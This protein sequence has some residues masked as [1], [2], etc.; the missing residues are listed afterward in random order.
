MELDRV[1]IERDS[2][3][4]ERDNIQQLFD[5]VQLEAEVSPC[6]LDP[7]K[8]KHLSLSDDAGPNQIS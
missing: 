6:C 8:R 1:K 2:A 4:A 3:G 5:R 7:C